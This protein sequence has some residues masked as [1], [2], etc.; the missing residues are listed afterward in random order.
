M[1]EVEKVMVYIK[2]TPDTWHKEREITQAIESSSS[3]KVMKRTLLHLV[4]LGGL[5]VR[6]RNGCPHRYQYK[7]DVV[8]VSK[9]QQCDTTVDSRL[10]T[11][12]VCSECRP[13]QMTNKE[14]AYDAERWRANRDQVFASILR[15][16][17]GLCVDRYKR[18]LQGNK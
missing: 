6:R 8:C 4:E 15:L 10:L 12:G 9:C 18:I 11:D 16:P 7:S 3:S 17:F 2:S 14:L 13:R 1:L 5:K